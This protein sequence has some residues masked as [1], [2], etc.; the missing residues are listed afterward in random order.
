MKGPGFSDRA[1][2][3]RRAAAWERRANAPTTPDAY[4]IPTMDALAVQ[5]G[6]RV[7]DIGC[8]PGTTAVQLATRVGP[9]GEVVGVDLS[10]AMAA[11]ATRRAAAAG[12]A[13]VR[14][15]AADAQTADLGRPFDAAFSR[16]GVMFFTEPGAAFANIGRALRPGG[17]IGWV[18]WGPAHDNP[19]LSVP[20]AASAR[21]LQIEVAVAGAD[22][23]GPF[24]L[25]DRERMNALLRRAGFTDVAVRGLA[26]GR[27]IGAVTAEE[28]I[29]AMLDEIG[30]ISEAYNAADDSTRQAAVAAVQ[31]AIEPFRNAGGWRLPGAAWLVTAH[32]A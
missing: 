1:Y 10:P 2:W 28:D 7:L 8:G 26:G 30:P 20:L 22:R 25:A 9:S 16:F 17:R 19:W 15:V 24:F 11:A 32:L 13:N 12:L 21:V 6:E 4:G 3:D 31:T 5:P 14:F 29:D 23:P 18:V 27:Q